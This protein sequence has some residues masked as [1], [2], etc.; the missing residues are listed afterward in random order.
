MHEIGGF[1]LGRI[2]APIV[3]SCRRHAFMTDHL[4]PGIQ[5]RDCPRWRVDPPILIA[6]SSSD[7][8][9]AGLWLV[10]GQVQRR[11]L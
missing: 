3:A 2:S 4:L 8:N 10:I 11:H 6:L 7:D 5:C 9:R 1:A